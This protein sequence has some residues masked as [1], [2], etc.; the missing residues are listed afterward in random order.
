M[1]FI[2]KTAVQRMCKVCSCEQRLWYLVFSKAALQT[3]LLPQSGIIQTDQFTG[4][5]EKKRGLFRSIL[6]LF[7]SEK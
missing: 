7:R 6:D 1:R 2:A 4:N 3:D 5:T